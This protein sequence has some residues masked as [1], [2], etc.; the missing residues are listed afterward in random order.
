M[1]LVGEEVWKFDDVQKL[2]YN[3]KRGFTLNNNSMRT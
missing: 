2:K 3:M 1:Y